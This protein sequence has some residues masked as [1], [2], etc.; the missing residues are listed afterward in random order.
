MHKIAWLTLA[1]TVL[2]L[3]CETQPQTATPPASTATHKPTPARHTPGPIAY[4][5]GQPLTDADLRTRL[6]EAAGGQ[7]LSELVLDQQIS[8]RLNQAGLGV[9]AE[10]IAQEKAHMLA[11]LSADPNEAVRLLN[12][13]RNERGLGEKRFQSMLFR[14]AGL[15]VLVQDEIEVSPTLIQQAYQL[16]HGERYRIRIIVAD[17]LALASRLRTQAL[18]GESFADLASLNSTDASA[19]QGGLLS[20]ISPIDATYPK[21]LRQALPKLTVGG[22]SDLIAADNHFIIMRLEEKLPADTVTLE[23]ARPTLTRTVRLELESQKMQQAA[24]SMLQDAKV[25]VLEPV[26]NKSWL[27]Q[28]GKTQQP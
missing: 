3:G 14:N 24:R 25:V 2:I 28:Q 7:V 13:M 11:T 23:Q 18:A 4:I 8:D 6:V 22:V 17:S 19:A 10:L 12:E 21:A 9:D 16:K 5:D 15:R 1:L 26:L 27:T 20:P